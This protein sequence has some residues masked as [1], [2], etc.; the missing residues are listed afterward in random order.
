M[1]V[2]VTGKA[3][4]NSRHLVVNVLRVKSFTQV[5]DCT[6]RGRSAPKTL[7]CSR[8]DCNLKMVMITKIQYS[9]EL[10]K[11]KIHC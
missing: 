5:F 6:G 8:I 10:F 11:Y 7:G 4:V 1:T 2:Y 3:S 9:P